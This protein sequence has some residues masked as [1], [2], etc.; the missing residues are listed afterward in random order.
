MG[1]L[2]RQLNS[3][4]GQPRDDVE[5]CRVCQLESVYR[6]YRHGD[7]D[8]CPRCRAIYYY[9]CT[10]R[11]DNGVAMYRRLWDFAYGLKL[12]ADDIGDRGNY[13]DGVFCKGEP[14]ALVSQVY[15]GVEW[16]KLPPFD[17]PKIR[18][19]SRTLYRIQ[20]KKDWEDR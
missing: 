3:G 16:E 10:S 19:D 2:E 14:W 8:V 13:R 11:W 15:E 6:L 12:M 1:Y 9:C 20:N 4:D 18:Q 5:L 7:M 17:P